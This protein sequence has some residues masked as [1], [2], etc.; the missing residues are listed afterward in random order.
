MMDHVEYSDAKTILTIEYSF[1]NIRSWLI[2][3]PHL[4]SDLSAACRYELLKHIAALY[5]DMG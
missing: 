3:A 1:C 4:T 2:L 5:L